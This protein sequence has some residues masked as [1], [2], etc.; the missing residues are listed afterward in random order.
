MSEEFRVERV[1]PRRLHDLRRRILRGGRPDAVV[2]DPRDDDATARHYAG[3]LGE[4]V[5]AS[6]SFYPSTSPRGGDAWML[7]Y[8]ATDLD[9]R[10]RGYG[11]ALLAYAEAELRGLG[12]SA[13][14]ANGRDSALGFYEHEGWE[15]LAD[16][17]HLSPE[18]ALPHHV[19]VKS[20]DG[21]DSRT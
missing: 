16:S 6:A 19:I 1:D 17:A 18:T 20:L 10:G 2:S 3:L 21:A 8:M 5:V 13:L 14:W 15:V 4:R 11:A 7:R 12:V 9:V